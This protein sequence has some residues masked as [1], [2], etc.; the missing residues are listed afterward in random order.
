MASSR[1]A[2]RSL[3][4]VPV[5]TDPSRVVQ[6][7]FLSPRGEARAWFKGGV[8]YRVSVAGRVYGWGEG[9]DVWAAVLDGS[10]RPNDFGRH[11]EK[12][13]G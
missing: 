3:P 9:P 7:R 13:R 2:A 8:C 5:N 6:E 11:N 12:H 1:R 10:F 4:A